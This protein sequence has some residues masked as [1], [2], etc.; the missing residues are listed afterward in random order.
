[1]SYSL[2]AEAPFPAHQATELC[3]ASLQNPQEL[4]KPHMPT[5][6][7]F[8]GVS[9]IIISAQ[10][11]Q[12]HERECW[13]ER[14]LGSHIILGR[15]DRGVCD[16]VWKRQEEKQRGLSMWEPQP[17]AGPL[18]LAWCP[19]KPV[20]PEHAAFCQLAPASR[21]RGGRAG[22]MPLKRNRAAVAFG[23]KEVLCVTDAQRNK[24]VLG[25]SPT[26]CTL[27][28]FSF[29]ILSEG[30]PDRTW[31]CQHTL[32]LTQSYQQ[33]PGLRHRCIYTSLKDTPQ[34][35]KQQREF[36]LE[37]NSLVRVGS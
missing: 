16:G 20:V 24:T 5:C 2:T 9:H 33:C 17:Q 19:E 36:W 15:R 37:P 28:L 12:R 25:E 27:C 23:L 11:Q 22:K 21:G 35:F 13:W 32:D 30:M 3:L 18:W 10:Y 6:P 7:H 14:V 29:L 4:L 8:W 1:M 34:N 31:S 26:Q